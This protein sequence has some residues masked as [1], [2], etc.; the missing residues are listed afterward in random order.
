MGPKSTLC[1][2][3]WSRCSEAAPTRD[4]ASAS[5]DP[6]ERDGAAGRKVATLMKDTFLLARNP[7]W[8]LSLPLNFVARAYEREKSCSSEV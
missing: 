7:L 2:P 1:G 8:G 3:K 6:D 5:G 4:A